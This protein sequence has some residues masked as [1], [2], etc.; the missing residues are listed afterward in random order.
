[1]LA[2]NCVFRFTGYLRDTNVA[3]GYCSFRLSD[4]LIIQAQYTVTINASF[5]NNRNKVLY[6]IYSIRSFPRNSRTTL[7]LSALFNNYSTSGQ[8]I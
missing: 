3:T 2:K 6:L 7:C 1:M 8:W 4:W 5:R